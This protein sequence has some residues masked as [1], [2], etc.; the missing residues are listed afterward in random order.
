MATLSG[1]ISS[2]LGIENADKAEFSLPS[3][4]GR[5]DLLW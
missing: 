4:E 2:T 5:A 1:A 3:G